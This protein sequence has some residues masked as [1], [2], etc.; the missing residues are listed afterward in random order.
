MGRFSTTQQKILL[1]SGKN[2]FIFLTICHD[3]SKKIAA[4]WQIVPLFFF[5]CCVVEDRLVPLR[6]NLKKIM[7]RF[8]T[9]QQKILL[10]S[11]KNFF[12][13][14]TICHDA[15]KKNCCV[16]ANRPIIFFFF[17]LLRSGTKRSSTTQQFKKNN[18]TIFHDATKKICCVV[19][20]IFS[21]S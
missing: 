4:S 18:G 21:F 20:R 8:S 11:G 16:V 3:A 10:R 9:T 17:L 13:F 1:R 2:F 12:I 15:S 6:S 19:E 7:G 14:L 5:A